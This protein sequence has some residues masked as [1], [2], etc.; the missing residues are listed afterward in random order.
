[1][2]ISE[3]RQNHRYQSNLPSPQ[4][5]ITLKF[6]GLFD[7]NFIFLSGFELIVPNNDGDPFKD[8][9]SNCNPKPTSLLHSTSTGMQPE[10]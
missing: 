1:M 5:V 6:F 3:V 4:R 10:Y 8:K 7:N 2:G 9:Y